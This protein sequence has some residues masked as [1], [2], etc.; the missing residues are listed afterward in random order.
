MNNGLKYYVAKTC[1][2]LTLILLALACLLPFIMVFS[3][4]VTSESTLL[5]KGYSLFPREFN[6]DAYSMIFRRPETIISAYR[7]TILITVVGTSVGVYLMSALGYTLSRRDFKW[8]RQLS[9]F[10]YFT[11]LFSG[12]TVS[13]YILVTQYLNLKNNL[14]A[15]ILPVLISVWNV[16]LLKMF[17]S[18]LPASLIESARLDGASE[19]YIFIRLAIP[20][21]KTGIA[22]IALF[23][24]LSYWNEWFGSM[25]YMTDNNKISLQY[26]LQKVLG[27]VN[28]MRKYGQNGMFGQNLSPGDSLKM[29]N[30]IIAAG[31]AILVFPFFQKYFVK[32]IMVGS[33]K[34]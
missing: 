27:D 29:A 1:L 19:Y 33:L 26:M 12:G 22:T 16:M 5:L 11:M 10:V 13:T 23:T 32:G 15:L 30:C 7:V 24:C 14:L 4:S 20:L 25:M 3:I 17:F 18:Q 9:F 2:Y 8:R 28:F 31:P 6:F 34:E 21:T